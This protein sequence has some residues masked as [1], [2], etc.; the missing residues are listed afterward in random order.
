MRRCLFLPC[1]TFLVGLLTFPALLRAD[2]YPLTT[3]SLP[4]PNVPRGEVTHATWKSRVFPGTERDYW[5][6]VPKQ[7]TAN[8]PACVMVFQDGGGFQD[9]NGGFRVPVVFDNLIHKKEMPV[10]IAIMINPGVVPAPRSGALPRF[11]RSFEY[12]APTDQ[13]ARFLLE[14]ILPEVGK[15]YNLT[16]DPA[17]R[18]LCGASSG[19]I[20]AFTTAWERPDQFSKVISFVGSFTN[21]R[22]GHA[23][24]SLIR[25]YEPR[26]IRVYMQDGSHDQDIYSG[27]WF[28]GNN[29]VA[30]ALRFGRYDMQYVVGTGGHDGIQGTAVLPE[31]LKWLWRDYPASL[32]LPESTPQPIMEVVKPG[33]EWEPIE[34]D[35]TAPQSV[36]ADA[37]GTVF[38]SDSQTHCLYKIGEEGRAFRCRENMGK[39]GSMAFGPDGRLYVSLP[40]KKQVVAYGE[41]KKEVVFLKG[42]A[43]ESITL[44]QKGELYGVSAQDGKIWFASKEGR[45]RQVEEEPQG[46]SGVTLTPDQTLLHVTYRREKLAYSFH[47][48]PNGNLSQKQ[49]YFDLHIPYGETLTGAGGMTTDRQGRLYVASSAGVQVCDQ[50]GR[51][52]GILSNPKRTPTKEVTF[53]GTGHDT[54]YVVAGNKIYRR[55]TKVQGVSSFQEPFQ[56]PSPRL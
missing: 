14:E 38:F 31:A 35:F 46:A 39:P 16:Q 26:P 20:C 49:A 24:P 34:G 3:D 5:V 22:G 56:P 27:S 36:A 28:I 32:R 50:A 47:I 55:K 9:R 21:L 54:L 19:G 37:T 43:L 10:T 51:V 15:K 7:Y 41:D 25:K 33:E 29:D 13:Y 53:G 18:G 2:D 17:G 48:E 52:I 4:Q 44:N 1:L 45:R 11:N 30:A 12:D 23:F 6:Y 42:V 40:E 8:K